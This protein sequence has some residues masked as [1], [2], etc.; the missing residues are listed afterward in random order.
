M[1]AETT[2]AQTLPNNTKEGSVVLRARAFLITLNEVYKY[3]DLKAVIRKL[4]SCDYFLSAKE[5]APTTGHEHIHIYIH[6]ESSYKLSK[7]IMSFGAHIDICNYGT[8]QDIINYVKKDG[9]ILDEIGKEPH[10]GFHTVKDLKEID[11]PDSL[12]WKEYNTWLKIKNTPK[13]IKKGEW[14][15]NVKVYWIQGPSGIGKSKYAEDL[16]NSSEFEEMEEVKYHN[17]FW[18]G[19]IDG[20]GLCI[21]D[22]FR[23]SHM[24]ASEF[25]NFID[26]RIHNL[27]V[28]GGS[29]KNNYKMI[30]I[31]SIQKITDIYKNVREEQKEQWIRRIELI[32][33][34]PKDENENILN[35]ECAYW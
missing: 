16:F 11:S 7:K 18:S 4:K 23:D 27:N 31:T 17:G 32:D 22:D 8:P 30:I 29:V 13:K 5:L 28:K 19:I 26:Y 33:L 1:T 3:E 25:I 20:N 14:L 34:Y 2:T 10:Q 6:F 9:E 24:S 35:D 15:K 21:Y 12:N